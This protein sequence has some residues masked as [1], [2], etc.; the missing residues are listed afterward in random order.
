MLICGLYSCT[1]AL[2]WLYYYLSIQTQVLQRTKFFLEE[3][4]VDICGILSL[5][6]AKVLEQK[7]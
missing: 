6:K 4:N 5:I 1:F 7:Y 3:E 2:I